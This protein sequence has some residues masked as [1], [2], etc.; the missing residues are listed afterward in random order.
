MTI[1]AALAASIVIPAK[2][3][4]SEFRGTAKRGSS[5]F[6]QYHPWTPAQAAAIAR[7]SE[8]DGHYPSASAS[9]EAYVNPP[10]VLPVSELVDELIKRDLGPGDPPTDLEWRAGLLAGEVRCQTQHVTRCLASADLGIQRVRAKAARYLQR[11]AEQR[12]E[13]VQSPCE[14]REVFHPPKRGRVP[15]PQRASGVRVDERSERKAGR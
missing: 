5:V 1:E 6:T 9:R 10:P 4:E 13:R 8:T 7:T 12:L 14:K 3:S 11:M 15:D 2:T